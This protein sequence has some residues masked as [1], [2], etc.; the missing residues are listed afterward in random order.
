[1]S[2][3]AFA[4]PPDLGSGG[5]F[6][7][8]LAQLAAADR[9]SGSVLVAQA[10]TPIF[11]VAHGWADQA[12]QRRNT[13][14]TKFNIGSLNKMFTAVAIAQLAEHGRL[15]FADTIG[16]YLPGWPADVAAQVTIHQLLTHTSGLRDYLDDPQY[17]AT[18][19][20]LCTVADLLPFVAGQPLAFPPG[21]QWAYSN[22]GYVVLGAIVETVAG[23]SYYDYVR[24]QIYAPAG[25]RDSDSYGRDEAIPNLA[26]GYSKGQDTADWLAGRGS[27]AGGGYATAGD[28]LQF[29]LALRGHRLLDAAM[30]AT[31]LAGKVATP[32]PT[33]PGQPGVQYAYGFGDQRVNG[34]RIVG[35]NG[36][37]PGI[38]AW[39]DMYPEQ[40]LT[41][42]VLGNCDEAARPV[43]R[44]ARQILTTALSPDS[45]S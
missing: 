42:V 27:P 34:V 4:L 8:F 1:M 38:S 39:F 45:P 28:L 21:S 17:Q 23:Q 15:A 37:G 13:L 41:F 44:Q 43:T 9:F 3:R 5:P 25:M 7:Q 32:L 29:S 30:T 10:A 22:A 6:A 16:Q 31:L 33:A 14:D 35:H 19:A 12:G 36:G 24:R 18:H 40:D 11:A 2:N 20:T 26:R